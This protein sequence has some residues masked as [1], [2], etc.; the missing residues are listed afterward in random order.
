ML[1]EIHAA[2][3]SKNFHLAKCNLSMCKKSQKILFVQRESISAVASRGTKYDAEKCN[4]AFK[5]NGR[6]RSCFNWRSGRALGEIG[7]A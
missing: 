2:G 1:I 7:G 5:I 6:T 4:G 3:K